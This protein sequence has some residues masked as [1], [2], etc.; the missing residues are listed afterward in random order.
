MNQDNQP[1]TTGRRLLRC[2]G[3]GHSVEC[4]SAELLRYTRSGWPRCCDTIMTYF[5]EVELPTEL[6]DDTKLDRP[7]LP[8]S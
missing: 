3:C 4:S 6:P 7:S 8:T 5:V 1:V 2:N